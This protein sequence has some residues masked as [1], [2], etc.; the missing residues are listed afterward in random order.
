MSTHSSSP[1]AARLKVITA[2]S[3]AAML[4][5]LIAHVALPMRSATADEVPS[6][7]EASQPAKVAGPFDSLAASSPSLRKAQSHFDSEPRDDHWAAA[8]ESRWNVALA[9]NAD[10]IPYGLPVVECRTTQCQ[11]RL[12][13]KANAQLETQQWVHMLSAGMEEQLVHSVGVSAPAPGGTAVVY[14]ATMDR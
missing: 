7:G 5:M 12:L 8:L 14:H 6:L 10:L 13:T 1:L 9:T 3:G 11:V 4:G 2:V